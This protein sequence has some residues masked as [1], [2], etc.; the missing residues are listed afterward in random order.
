MQAMAWHDDGRKLLNTNQKLGTNNHKW[1]FLAYLE[2]MISSS[3]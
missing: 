1:F 2:G 3:I